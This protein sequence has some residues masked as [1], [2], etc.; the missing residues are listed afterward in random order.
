MFSNA[1]TP[2]APLKTAVD[3]AITRVMKQYDIPGM[4]VGVIADGQPYVF[5]YGVTA[6]QGGQAVSGDTLF[7]LGSVSKLFTALLGA[8]AQQT[9]KLE[10]DAP[11][12]RYWAALKGSAF[13]QVLMKELVTYSAGGLPLQFPDSVSNKEGSLADYYRQWRPAYPHGEQRLYS[14]PSIGLFGYLTARSLGLPFDRAVETIL[15]PKL[16]MNATRIRLQP[17]D[18]AKY[19]WGVAEHDERVRVTPGALD[20]EAYGVKSSSQDMLKLLS[21]NLGEVKDPALRQAVAATQQARYQVGDMRQGLGWEIY[22]YPVSLP[23]LLAGNNNDMAFKPHKTSWFAE[24]V[25]LPAA[26]Y[27]KTGSTRGFGAYVMVAPSQKAGIVMLAN[28]NYPNS[29][30]VTAAYQILSAVA[31]Q[32]SK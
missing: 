22:P 26:L 10:W 9:G 2:P 4:S 29:E 6:R 13:D 5:N 27:N 28:R 30:R 31:G 32:G 18:A 1:A 8:Y 14:N 17:A 20:A 19:A 11:A 23:T 3:A 7:E 15:L 25:R 12:S 21:A 16:G 24:P